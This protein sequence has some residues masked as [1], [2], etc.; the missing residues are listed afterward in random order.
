METREKTQPR[1]ESGLVRLVADFEYF[2]TQKTHLGVGNGKPPPCLVTTCCENFGEILG[3]N[4][5]VVLRFLPS[6]GG[7]FMSREFVP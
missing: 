2:R 4:D 5:G 7:V 6:N 3:R 1:N